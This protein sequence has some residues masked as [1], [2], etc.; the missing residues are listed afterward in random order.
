MRMRMRERGEGVE[1]GVGERM[2]KRVKKGWVLNEGDMELRE[3]E[4]GVSKWVGM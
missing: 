3:G 1:N 4:E 2:K